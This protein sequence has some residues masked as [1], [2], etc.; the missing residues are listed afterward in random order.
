[1]F[2]HIVLYETEIT[3]RSCEVLLRE[4]IEGV[5]GTPYSSNALSAL[6]LHTIS[7]P[8]C[9]SSKPPLISF[10]VFRTASLVVHGDHEISS[11]WLGRQVGSTFGS[12]K[13]LPTV[14]VL[15]STHITQ[16]ME[17]F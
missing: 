4:E 8:S 1:M 14:L 6:W 13:I 10:I 11:V 3:V 5:N 15:N 12:P 9:S 7:L 17:S 2:A 16:C